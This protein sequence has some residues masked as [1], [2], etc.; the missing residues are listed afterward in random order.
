MDFWKVPDL[1]LSLFLSAFL[2]Y[3]SFTVLC[4]LHMCWLL[5]NDWL[6]VVFRACFLCMDNS[7]FDVIEKKSTRYLLWENKVIFSEE[8]LFAFMLLMNFCKASKMFCL[9]NGV[10]CHMCLSYSKR[11]NA[12]WLP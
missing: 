5:E 9:N 11:H 10:Y 7:S 3:L 12:T 4:L 6:V 8:K 2:S 1:S